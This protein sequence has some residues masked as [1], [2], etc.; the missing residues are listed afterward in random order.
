MF[1]ALR[2]IRRSWGRF[3]LLG[4]VVALIVLLLV[5]LTG[6]TGGL[7][8]QNTSALEALDP[9]RYVFSGAQAVPGE[10]P[11]VDFV[12]SRVP[13]ETVS[14]WRSTPG[15][16]EVTPLGIT[17]TSAQAGSQTTSVAVLGLPEGSEVPGGGTIPAEGAL[18]PDTLD[19]PATLTMSGVEVPVAGTVAEEYYSH[20]PVVWV[21]MDT[22]KEV[23]HSP[24]PTVLMLDGEPQ[25]VWENTA[26][27]TGSA[28]VSVKESFAGLGAY[29]SERGSLLSIQGLL[30]G[31]SALVI[32]AF[33]SVWTIQRTRDIAVLRALGASKSY[34][35]RDSLGQAALILSAGAA[36]GAV[37][38]TAL[39]LAARQVVPFDLSVVT[40]VLPTVGVLVLGLLGAW[41][42]TRRVSTIDPQLALN[43]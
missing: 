2:D 35:L 20:L 29:Q 11:E 38:A 8:K 34:V 39:G 23:A 31:I 14:A 13:E 28:A 27:A 18:L 43:N 19:A 5:M 25:E 24:A 30:Y 12:E 37:V 36:V 42:A 10:T 7:G 26:E 9:Q 22:W 32:V 17:Q 6:L 16:T 3:S 15:V 33:L 40:V 1:L 4:I 21:G 41:L